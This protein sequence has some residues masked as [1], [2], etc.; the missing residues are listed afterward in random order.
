MKKG[1]ELTAIGGEL[2]IQHDLPDH[3]PKTFSKL[4]LWGKHQIAKLRVV[5]GE[6]PS[7][8][9]YLKKIC[10][11]LDSVCYRRRWVVCSWDLKEDLT[12]EIVYSTL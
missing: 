6:L 3:E 10:E 12:C 4:K 1:A 2:T 11:A 8:V 7:A 5:E 9:S